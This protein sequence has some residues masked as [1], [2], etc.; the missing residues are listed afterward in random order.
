MVRAGTLLPSDRDGKMCRDIKEGAYP[1]Y[2]PNPRQDCRYVFPNRDLNNQSF[3][4]GCVG[5]AEAGVFRKNSH[6]FTRSRHATRPQKNVPLQNVSLSDEDNESISHCRLSLLT[7]ISGGAGPFP[8]LSRMIDINGLLVISLFHLTECHLLMFPL[9][10]EDLD[11]LTELNE[12][13]PSLKRFVHLSFQWSF[14]VA[15]FNLHFSTTHAFD[16]AK[17]DVFFVCFFWH[18]RIF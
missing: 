4:L 3:Q 6:L 10:D 15:R 7:I 14:Q 17:Y 5:P 16:F 9:M 12:L 13:N 8:P 1:G 18:L 11:V 2:V